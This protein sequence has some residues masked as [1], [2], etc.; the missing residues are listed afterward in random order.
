MIFIIT[1]SIADMKTG[2]RA[3]VKDF[4]GG[5][6]L[7]RKVMALG[8]D[9]G[10]EIM[11]IVGMEEGGPFIIENITKGTKIAMGRGIARKIIVEEIE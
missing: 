9:P 10:D 1:M 7:M 3:K 6:G 8:I 4:I 11:V 2:K 5:W